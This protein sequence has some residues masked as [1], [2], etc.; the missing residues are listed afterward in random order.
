MI[1]LLSSMLVAE[2]SDDSINVVIEEMGSD[3]SSDVVS[4]SEGS[5]TTPEVAS[6]M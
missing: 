5:A 1:E 2:A 4:L 6:G 3:A